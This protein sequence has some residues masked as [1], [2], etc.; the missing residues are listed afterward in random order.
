MF[1]APT[2]T[3]PT[4]NTNWLGN[5]E[6]D[7]DDFQGDLTP[8]SELDGEF[9]Q[10]ACL[11]HGGFGT[12]V[13]AQ[14]KSGR[15]VALKISRFD[16][17]TEDVEECRSIWSRE[18]K[19]VLQLEASSTCSHK[20]IVPFRDWFAGPNY[21]CIVMNYCDGGTL[22]QEI[23]S[24]TTVPYT[25]R[26]IAWYALQLSGALAFAHQQGVYHHDVKSENVLID[27]AGGGNLVLTDWGSA[28]STG[29]ES[30]KF[31]ELYASP[32]FT[33]AYESGNLEGLD[34]QKI[35]S[36]GLGCILY[37][38]LCCKKLIDLSPNPEDP[39]LGKFIGQRSVD[40]ALNM[41]CIQLPWLPESPTEHSATGY[42]SAL[43]GLVKTLLEP[44]PSSRYSPLDLQTPFRTDPRSPLLA[45]YL[46]AALPPDPGAAVTIDN[47][48]LGMLVQRG[49]D[50]EEGGEGDADGGPGSIGVVVELDADAGYT[51]VVFPPRVA[52]A[53]PNPIV[54]RIGEKNKFELQVAPKLNDFFAGSS[55]P[56]S[57]GLIECANA[58]DY[59]YC[60][61]LNNDCVVLSNT[62]DKLSGTVDAC[63]ILVAP[64]Q[65]IIAPTQNINL[66]PSVTIDVP[67]KRPKKPPASWDRTST[68]QQ[69]HL[70][71]VTD[72]TEKSLILEPFYALQGGL[73]IQNCEI[74][75]I[76][77]VQ[78]ESLWTEYASFLETVAMENWGVPNEQ[79]LFHGT[80]QHSPE[81]LLS[82]PSEFYQKCVG[83]MGREISFSAESTLAD[84]CG[85][86]LPN[87]GLT[88][89]Q[90]FLSRVALGRVKD[91]RHNS[92]RP[93]V[94]KKPLE[95]HSKFHGDQKTYSVANPFSSY[96]EF[97]IT[98]KV[99]STVPGRRIVSA[100]RT[101]RGTRGSRRGTRGPPRP[102]QQSSPVVN[103]AP[104][105]SNHAA[106]I[107]SPS[108]QPAAPPSSFTTPPATIGRGN[109]MTPAS[110]ASV[111][112]ECVVC[113]ERAV[114]HILVPCGHPCLCEV[115]STSQGLAKLRKKCPECRASIQQAVRFYGRIVED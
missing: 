38:M 19:F 61:M 40:E 55:T 20:S 6:D 53:E 80:G 3:A 35:D 1:S 100:R 43:R 9:E 26:R 77:R 111:V 79:R 42:S 87:Q 71:E 45:P 115:C 32:E 98:Y 69:V 14:K 64:M 108:A 2:T 51:S 103:A 29:E 81:T 106:S 23:E 36:F 78:C 12:V 48:Q 47:I 41:G 63:Y 86:R 52:D 13:L 66:P 109:P 24:H 104:V 15:Q 102:T 70:V 8:L 50:W 67:P 93:A 37:E 75:S 25:E 31:T 54:V 72:P 17:D 74:T 76:K 18:V 84:R 27:R 49:R 30:I 105:A 89:K 10:I 60:Q 73:D 34:P 56:R 58:S 95:F 97:L 22:A 46:T 62:Q 4:P 107:A 57:N 11:G 94:F 113:L 92:V 96:P 101:N 112:K 21:A 82:S 85:Y 28:I 5:D 44:N 83:I 68:Q 99:T 90:I 88:V 59:K 39:T 114:T 110:T 65:K 91:D 16:L 33:A 7:D